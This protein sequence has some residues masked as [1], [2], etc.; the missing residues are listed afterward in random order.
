MR[1]G[2]V[3]TE[4]MKLNFRESQK[5]TRQVNTDEIISIYDKGIFSIRQIAKEYKISHTTVRRWLAK[6]GR[7]IVKGEHHPFW[8][9]GKYRSCK[10]YI[11]IRKVGY[12]KKATYVS[13]HRL[14]WEQYYK[15]KLPKGW[16]IHHLNGIKEDNRIENLFALPQKEHSKILK[17]LQDKIACLEKELKRFD[18]DR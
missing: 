16:V 17:I 7:N 15:Q 9:G 13:E 4:E 14:I 3:C 1:K 18:K 12:Y 8:K 6:L 2:Q 10:G 5:R 11:M